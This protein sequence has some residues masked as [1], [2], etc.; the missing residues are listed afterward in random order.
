MK[1]KRDI[2]DEINFILP[3]CWSEEGRLDLVKLAKHYNANI[4]YVQFNDPNLE[5]AVQKLGTGDEMSYEIAIKHDSSPPRK[6][7]TLAHEIGHI[8]SNKRGSYSEKEFE[9]GLIKDTEAVLYRLF[10]DNEDRNWAEIEANEI[11]ANLLM[12]ALIIRQFQVSGFNST[13]IAEILGVSQQAYSI[14][15]ANLGLLAYE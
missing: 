12:P 14:R 9:A 5:G 3:S 8:I 2:T 7:F 15:C 1:L 10:D 13:K 4:S 11:A 6:R